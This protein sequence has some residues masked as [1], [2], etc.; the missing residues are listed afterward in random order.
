M[1]GRSI[2]Q[3]A[4]LAALPAFAVNPDF[5]NLEEVIIAT[6]CHLDVGYTATVPQLMEKYS[7]K[8]LDRA[9]ALFES[10]RDKPAMRT[11]WRRKES[12]SG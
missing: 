2:L 7:T 12:T 8:D 1:D 6:K 5:P 4:M 3:L 11:A 9:F 10:D